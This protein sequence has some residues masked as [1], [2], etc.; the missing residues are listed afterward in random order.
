M[1]WRYHDKEIPNQ[2]ACI[3]ITASRGSRRR[4]HKVV[5][6][7]ART[8]LCIQ[9]T[10]MYQPTIRVDTNTQN[11]LHDVRSYDGSDFEQH[12]T[13]CVTT[14]NLTDRYKSSVVTSRKTLNSAIFGIP[15][16]VLMKVKVFEHTTPYILESTGV[17][18]WL[19][20]SKRR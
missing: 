4:N 11:I 12:R 2:L 15:K 9:K 14:C 13:W 6:S 3:L 8:K 18:H 10:V 19:V 17:Q 20:P 16:A 1:S 5:R 7:G